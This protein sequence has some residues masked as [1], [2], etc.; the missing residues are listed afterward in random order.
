MVLGLQG[1]EGAQ[2]FLPLQAGGAPGPGPLVRGLP[3]LLLRRLRVQLL[4]D[5]IQGEGP[6]QPLVPQEAGDREH[7]AAVAELFE[8]PRPGG[9]GFLLGIGRPVA[10]L[11]QEP[12]LLLGLSELVPKIPGL[13]SELLGLDDPLEPRLLVRPVHEGGDEGGDAPLHVEAGQGLRWVMLLEALPELGDLVRGQGPLP[14]RPGQDVVG[15]LVLGES[16]QHTLQVVPRD[17]RA[18]RKPLLHQCL[19]RGPPAALQGL[20][21]LGFPEPLRK[22]S[23]RLL[24]D[25][26]GERGAHL[27]E[28]AGFDQG[29]GALYSIT[30]SG[31]LRPAGH[32]RRIPVMKGGP[33][34]MRGA[35]R[36]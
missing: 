13:G 32:E 7:E 21:R 10:D 19:H 23:S 8:V 2:A 26:G 28:E 27:R 12:G 20:L 4:V 18:L 6:L 16:P 14:E 36:S 24:D 33:S 9:L 3:G 31:D 34:A 11:L 35:F 22:T 17:V 29:H 25:P 5:P 30:G 1:L 15:H